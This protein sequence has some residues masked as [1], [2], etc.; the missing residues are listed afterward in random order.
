[1]NLINDF[2][3]MISNNSI[4]AI[5]IALIGGIVS[6]FSPCVLSTLPLI[7]GYLNL[8]E[9]K[10]KEDKVDKRNSNLRLSLS[11]SLGIVL[12]FTALGSL[13]VLLGKNLRIWGSYWYLFLAVILLLSSLQLIGVINVKKYCKI[14]ILKKNVF[15]AF[16]LGIIGGIFCSPCSTP[17]LVAILAYISEKSN[18]ILGI[19]LMISYSLGFCILIFLSG[20]YADFINRLSDNKK[21][22]K[23]LNILQILLGIII[24][25]FSF[26]LFYLGF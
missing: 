2:A 18:I 3:A 5:I 6:S 20:M 24:L 11:F 7:I 22:M 19:I 8:D 23:S 10:K 25:F 14:P 15:G 21:Y 4:L 26:Y 12:T 17:I 13:S 1:M 9:N 16:F